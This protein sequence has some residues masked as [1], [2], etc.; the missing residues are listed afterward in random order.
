LMRPTPWHVGAVPTVPGTDLNGA[1]GCRLAVR[2]QW[3][4]GHNRALRRPAVLARAELF[5]ARNNGGPAGTRQRG[6]YFRS[7]VQVLPG[8]LPSFDSIGGYSMESTTVRSPPVRDRQRRLGALEPG[9]APQS[10]SGMASGVHALLPGSG[11]GPGGRAPYRALQLRAPCSRSL[12]KASA[13]GR[14]VRA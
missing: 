6:Q 14:G 4:A 5:S 11:D 8:V 12:E 2:L 7:A 9:C 3:R 10:A 13:R 1:A